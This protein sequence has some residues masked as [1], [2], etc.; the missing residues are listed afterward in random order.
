M[1]YRDH[2][3][4]AWNRMVARGTPFAKVATDEECAKPLEVLDSRGWLP[5][6]VVGLDVLCLA[7][8]GGWQSILYAAAGARVTV[9]DISGA[10]LR[11][12]EREAAKRNLSVTTY[13]GSMDDLS[14]F[15]DESFDIVHQPVSTC[16]VPIIAA[17]Y[18]EVARVLRDGGLY[19]SQHK[20]PASL[21]V[22]NHTDDFQYILG[23]DY[24]HKGPLPATLDIAYR[25]E[26]TIEYMHRLEQIVGDLCRAGFVLEDFR[27]PYRADPAAA[28]G[29]YK[30]RS[31][32]VPPY[33]R[34]KA[35]R[36]P[37]RDKNA[38]D[39]K[40]PIWTP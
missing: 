4:A 32:F 1:S 12:D 15:R 25:E 38:Q 11:Q 33:L 24:Y 22:T 29:H 14:K 37:R 3:K 39:A 16:Y 28:P 9:V 31:R 21:Q 30:H 13:E 34:M 6:S 8:G 17:V 18:H 26:G 36:L 27:E 23:V 5:K 35:R 19:I 20:Q 40:S 10:M 2:N 7:A